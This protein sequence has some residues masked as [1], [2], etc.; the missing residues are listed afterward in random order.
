MKTD[1]VA[2]TDLLFNLLLGFGF[3][4]IISF[5]LIRPIIE[6]QHDLS[7][8]AEFVI[9]MTWPE[10]DEKSDDIDIW[11]SDPAGNVASFRNKEK[12]LIHIDRDDKGH[13][14]DIVF[15]PSGDTVVYPYN[16]EIVTIRGFIKGEWIINIHRYMDNTNKPTE[17]SVVMDKLNP[18]LTPIF[19][20]K[21][22]LSESWEEATVARLEMTAQGKIMSISDLP[23]GLVN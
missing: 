21:I 3:L 5:L 16:Q 1:N 6:K 22:I 14:N 18:K 2:F 8:K 10:S 12:G 9:K 13:I 19:N 11:I 15:L 7:T 4:F 23:K 20:K 17:V